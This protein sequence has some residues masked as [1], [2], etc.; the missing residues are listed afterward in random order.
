MVIA[1]A[2]NIVPV[3]KINDRFNVFKRIEERK[4]KIQFTVNSSVIRNPYLF[5]IF[6]IFP[7]SQSLLNIIPPSWNFHTNILMHTFQYAV[8]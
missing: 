1:K 2:A 6:E 4:K 3:R 8:V 5:Q 7:P